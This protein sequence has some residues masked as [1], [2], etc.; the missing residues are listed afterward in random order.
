MQEWVVFVFVDYF[1][2]RVSFCLLWLEGLWELSDGRVTD[3][4]YRV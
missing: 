3:S 2:W 1:Y 4:D